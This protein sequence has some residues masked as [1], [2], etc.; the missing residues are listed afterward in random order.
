MQYTLAFDSPQAHTNNPL[1][2]RRAI[3][4]MFNRAVAQAKRRRLLARFTGR[5]TQLRTLQLQNKHA[6]GQM[7]G[8][9]I[10][11]LDQIVGSEGRCHDFDNQFWPLREHNRDRWVNIAQ[12]MRNRKGL[13]PVQLIHTED[14]YFVRDGN[15]RISVAKTLGQAAIEAEVISYKNKQALA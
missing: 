14:G 3:V 11:S 13:P 8:L 7:L 2:Q 4:Q 6:E 12:A 9:Q 1:S 10:V 15:H 5:S